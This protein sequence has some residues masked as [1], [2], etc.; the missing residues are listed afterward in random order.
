MT[1]R[2]ENREQAGKLL[3]EKLLQYQK[4]EPVILA[5]PRGG[6]PI[7]YEIATKLR[8][9][10][11]V[12]FVKK[13]GAPGHEEF[14]IGA[15]AEDEKPILNHKLIKQYQ[16]N[17]DEIESIIVN[18]I[19]EIR[20]R[21]KN[22]RKKLPPVS[23]EG[24]TVIVVDDGLATGATMMAAIEWLHTQKTNKIIVAVPVSSKEAAYEIKKTV[25]IFLSILTPENFM[26]VGMWYK[27][28]PQVS[29]EEV[30]H[31]L[32]KQTATS[33]IPT[34]DVWIEDEMTMLQGVL[35]V[36]PKSRGLILFAHG[37]GSSH[38]SP[39]NLFV[40]KA[41]NDAGFGT[42][43][44]DLLTVAEALDRK[45][46]FDIDLMTKRLLVATDWAK[47]NCPDLPI[48]YF[49]ASTGAAAALGAAEDRLDIF[50]VV[51]RG[52]RPDLALEA[53]PKVYAPTLLLVGAEDHP[54]IPLNQL[55]KDKLKN[56]QMVLIPRAGHLFEEAGTLEQVVE[57]AVTW[58]SN[59]I[60]LH[61]EKNIPIKEN[62]IDEIEEN[63]VPFSNANDLDSWLKKISKNRIIMLGEATHGTKEFY[64]IRREITKKL[65]QNYGYS[66]VA[67]EG[68]WPDCYKLNEYINDPVSQDAKKVV[69]DQFHRWP[70]WMWANEEIPPLINWMKKNQLGKFYGLDVYSLFDSLE[71]IEKH[72]DHIDPS[73]AEK[74][75]NG[76]KCFES[77]KF[78]EIA[79][80]K[81]LL[82]MPAGCLEEVV[83]NLRALLRV[84]LQETSLTKE[85][86][87]DAKQNARVIA[88]AE[89]YYRSMLT[90]GAESWNVRDLHMMDTLENLL[91]LHGPDS[92]AIVWAHNTHIGDYHAT[93]MVDNGY[94]NLGG[95]ARER[96][97]IENVFLLGLSTY[98]GEVTAGSA[99][100]GP[101]KKMNL[102]K[103]HAGSYEDYFHQAALNMKTN[104]FL[105][106]FDKLDKNSSLY[107]KLGHRAVGVVYDPAHES[108][109]NYVPTQ[110]AKRYDGLI[111]VDQTTAVKSLPTSFTMEEFPE[112]WPQGL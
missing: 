9:P 29:D 52:G 83:S 31:F 95:L 64:S 82:K 21:S 62:I 55:A 11:D 56:C 2:F 50:A 94:L 13:I 35:T 3:A 111:F 103:A 42:L 67:V 96:F 69:H 78:D 44:F 54:V 57:Y 89:K 36:P 4:L 20:E 18:R 22:Y 10:L 68:D 102:P 5:L 106:T 107:R 6:V 19:S 86:L 74:M 93:D 48:G 26:A 72:L 71:E 101:E 24:R 76:Y 33:Q 112:T 110:M 16:F 8:A 47:R 23:L 84:R 59:C 75:L 66:F 14:A 38:K 92:K 37:G 46:V 87:F 40:A 100:G 58:F 73:L 27:D 99:W 17:P 60:S 98:Q 81:S 90:G 32:L 61:L 49:G 30:L 12:V 88:N 109:G 79:Y 25:D 77:Y 34:R 28:F 7:A 85:A 1:N 43:L 53:L 65:I 45:N 91:H 97:G 108:R 15:V 39:R 63:S 104:Q 105:T 80:A 70:T 51:S 41:L